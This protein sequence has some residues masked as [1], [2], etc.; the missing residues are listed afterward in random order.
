MIS[1]ASDNHPTSRIWAACMSLATTTQQ[2]GQETR[3]RSHL[4]VIISKSLVSD[5]HP[6]FRIWA[7][8][9]VCTSLNASYRSLTST[10]CLEHG[11]FDAAC[12]FLTIEYGCSRLHNNPTS[13]IWA[14]WCR[15]IG[16]IGAL[17]S[18]GGLWSQ[19]HERSMCILY[20]GS[21]GTHMATC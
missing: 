12:T 17:N 6:M 5:K 15:H 8:R 10:Q 14:V 4:S 20:I 21:H 16:Q 3:L 1:H 11:L 2:T 9:L 7:V 13:G 18:A 19:L